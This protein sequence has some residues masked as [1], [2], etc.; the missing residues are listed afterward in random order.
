MLN[1]KLMNV[2]QKSKENSKKLLRK[3]ATSLKIYNF[4]KLNQSQKQMKKTIKKQS[5]YNRVVT[6]K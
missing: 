3:Y 2:Y 5:F 6:I 4:L 1:I